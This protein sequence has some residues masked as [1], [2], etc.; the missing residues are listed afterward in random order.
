MKEKKELLAQLDKVVKGCRNCRLWRTATNAVPG[1]G[2]VKATVLFIGEAPGFH[3]DKLARPFVGRAGVLLEEQLGKVG[4]RREEVYITN[5]VKHRP[6]DNRGPNKDEIR[7]CLPYLLRQIQII[8][9][10]IIVPLGRFAL[11]VF[12][13]DQPI[14]KIHGQPFKV[15]ER[16]VLPLYHPAAALRSSLVLQDLKQDFMRLPKALAGEIHP[17]VLEVKNKDENQLQLFK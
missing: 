8:N 6:P 11:E 1:E 7:A 9:P 10:K 2:S 15:G 5:V 14:S 12:I 13:K 16:I 4:L 3:E 17:Q